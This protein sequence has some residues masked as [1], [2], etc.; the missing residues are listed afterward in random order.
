M[1]V[2]LKKDAQKAK[3][4]SLLHTIDA[5][6]LK[7][8]YSQGDETTI[9]GLIGDTSKVDTD[10]LLANEIVSDVRRITEPYKA[11]LLYTSA[12]RA[13]KNDSIGNSNLRGKA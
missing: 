4:D 10:S 12:P 5:L 9:I 13:A 7:T 3:I 1:I 2:I 11:C 8:H 6:G